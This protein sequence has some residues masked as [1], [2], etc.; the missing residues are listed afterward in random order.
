VI[1]SVYD[2]VSLPE[3]DEAVGSIREQTFG[4]FEFLIL[5]DGVRRADLLERLNRFAADDSR[6]RLFASAE[7]LGLAAAMNRLLQ[8]A[9]GRYIARMDA[10]DVSLPERLERQVRFLDEHRDVMVLGTMAVETDSDGRPQFEKILP[11]TDAEIRALQCYRDPF[12]HPSVMFRRELFERV[13]AYSEHARTLLLEDTDLWSR[14]LLEGLK[15]ANLPEVLLR[16][17][18]NAG[19]YERRGGFDLAWRELRLRWCYARRAGYAW[20]RRLPAFGVALMRIG[21]TEFR[22]RLYARCR[23]GRGLQGHA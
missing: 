13:G 14:T 4:D 11:T 15:T 23:G 19:L 8:S 10:D 20:H 18:V 12:V 5:Q 2:G 21:P 22:R 3:L 16:F 9:T 6:I 1:L 7:R 17:R